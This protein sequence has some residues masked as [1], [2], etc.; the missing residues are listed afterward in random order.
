MLIT[1]IF[2]FSHDVFYT[3]KDKFCHFQE[4]QLFVSLSSAYAFSLDLSKLYRS[5]EFLIRH[6][7]INELGEETFDMF[8]PS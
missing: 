1:S 6:C 2:T 4:R 7:S 5:V 3:I 8:H